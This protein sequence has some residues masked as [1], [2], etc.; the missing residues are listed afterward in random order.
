VWSLAC[1]YAEAIRKYEI[2][3]SRFYCSC[4]S[5]WFWTSYR[6]IASDFSKK[7][8]ACIWS[9]L[10]RYA[11]PMLSYAEAVSKESLLTESLS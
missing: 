6:L 5:P 11:L 2:E 9:C 8:R 1:K 7:L 3:K 10:T 4:C